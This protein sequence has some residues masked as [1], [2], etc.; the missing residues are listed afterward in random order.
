MKK[1]SREYGWAALGVYLAL[2]A[3]DLPFCFL[4]VRMLGTDRIGHWEHVVMETFKSF[5]KWPLPTAAQEKIDTAGD[6]VNEAVAG[7]VKS[8]KRMLEE[9]SREYGVEEIEDHGYK[10]ADKANRGADASIWTQLGLAYVIHKSFIFVRVPL[11]AAITP[12]VVKTLRSWGWN[13]G[14]MPNRKAV[15]SV[16]G[17]G[18]RPSGTPAGVN[19][20]GSKVRPDD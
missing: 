8:S 3:L 20:K 19:T 2:T 15:K 1:L 9:S 13:I 12:K 6:L 18:S 17:S 7:D 16:S 5:V 11:A 10:E 14:K 4:A